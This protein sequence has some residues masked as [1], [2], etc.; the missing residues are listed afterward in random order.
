MAN[1]EIQQWKDHIRIASLLQV[2][3]TALQSHSRAS[4]LTSVLFIVL[5]QEPETATLCQVCPTPKTHHALNTHTHTHTSHSHVQHIPRILIFKNAWIVQRHVVCLD[6][7]ASRE[8]AFVQKS[9]TQIIVRY[10]RWEHGKYKPSSLVSRSAGYT[11][12]RDTMCGGMWFMWLRGGLLQIPEIH[13]DEKMSPA[14]RIKVPWNC[15][16]KQEI[17][18]CSDLVQWRIVAYDEIRIHFYMLYI[19]GFNINWRF[20]YFKR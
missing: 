7:V 1:S 17:A 9:T 5:K 15:A 11:S 16:A 2:T 6:D 3:I 18:L 4:L 20:I 14:E 12:S 8:M 10:L 19:V 13:G